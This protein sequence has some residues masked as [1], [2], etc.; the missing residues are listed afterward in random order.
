MCMNGGSRKKQWGLLVLRFVVGIVFIYH[1]WMK[2]NGMEGATGMMQGIGLPVPMFWA[3]L[4][5]LVEFV[6]GI[7][8]ILGLF[9]RIV[10]ALLAIN[11]VVALL[12][13]H[14]KMPYGTGTELPIVLLGA[15]IALH[16]V[17]PGKCAL[18]GRKDHGCACVPGE[19]GHGADAKDGCCGGSCG[20]SDE[21]EKKE[22]KA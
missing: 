1:G 19:E 11:M 18:M 20:C 3:W 5:A 6:G 10:T 2:L 12:T 8:I 22:T 15:L 17:G 13:V 14:I 9:N 16:L 7:A 4:V 21:D